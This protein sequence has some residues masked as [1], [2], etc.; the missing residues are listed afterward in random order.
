LAGRSFPWRIVIAGLAV[1]VV[2][3]TLL[4]PPPGTR[5]AAG[6]TG[7]A[8]PEDVRAEPGSLQKGNVP[9]TVR[10]MIRNGTFVDGL[11]AKTQL[12]LL[13]S[14]SDSMVVVTP[15]DPSNAPE[16]P[17]RETVVASHL[18]D[19]SAAVVVAGLLGLGDGNVVWEVPPGGEEPD[20]DVTVY[21]GMD[22]KDR[23]GV[24]E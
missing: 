18:E 7:E 16:R 12:M 19:P 6:T 23:F 2:V 11:A 1:A 21:L 9:D 13:R 14:S 22:M 8:G 10:V 17:C 20:V 15:F 3:L 5:K 24:G 4:I